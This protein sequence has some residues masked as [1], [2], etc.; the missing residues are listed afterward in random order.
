MRVAMIGKGRTGRHLVDVLSED[1]I[2]GPFDSENPPTVTALRTADVAIAFVPASAVPTLVPV[3]LQAPLPVFWGTTG[4]SWSTSIRQRVLAAG[5]CWLLS[6]NFCAGMHLVRAL[7]Q[8][9]RAWLP[10]LPQAQLRIDETHHRHKRD[11][12]SGTALAWQAALPSH[13]PIGAH[14]QGDVI[15][16]HSL[17]IQTPHE[18]LQLN[19]EVHD[20]QA[21]AEGALWAAQTLWSHGLPAPG[22]HQLADVLANRVWE[23]A[24]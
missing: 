20:R 18:T 17:T 1:A 4:Y 3:L 22:I 21:F 13:V 12:P 5:R 24:S 9:V 11:S 2:V 6:E 14:R 10:H 16:C 19:H 15:G 8:Q 7:L 23:V